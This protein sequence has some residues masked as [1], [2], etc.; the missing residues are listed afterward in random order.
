MNRRRQ[1]AWILIFIVD[2]SYIAW[3]GMAAL[4]LNS[5]LG[6][7]G[8][9]ILA[10]GYE[11]FT[12]ASW[13]GLLST[14]PMTARYIDMLFRLYGAYCLIF[15]LIGSA[16]AITAFRRGER[17][18]W[19]T[20]LIGNTLALVSA[21]SYDKTVNAIGPFEMTEYLGLALV[22]LAFAMTAPL[23]NEVAPRQVTGAATPR[24]SSGG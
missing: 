19:W 14:D 4:F 8:K 17:W 21:M 3:G 1:V 10:A 13:A 15:G 18:A 20:L 9:P 11:G 5:L 2:L 6:P 22:L 16:I 7:G 12:S 24:P 23:G